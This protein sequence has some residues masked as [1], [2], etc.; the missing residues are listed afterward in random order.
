[1][2]TAV[3]IG[4]LSSQG[5]QGQHFR[6]SRWVGPPAQTVLDTEI[7]TAQLFRRWQASPPD[8]FSVRWSGTLIVDRPGIYTFTTVSDGV[9][10]L[11]I[12][13]QLVADNP[14]QR[15]EKL[16]VVGRRHRLDSG[17][18]SVVLEYAHDG[19]PYTLEWW[20]ARDGGA[21]KPVPRRALS[22]G[23]RGRVAIFTRWFDTLWWVV[24][25]A[26][27]LLGAASAMQRVML[28]KAV[29]E[30][31]RRPV[32]LVLRVTVLVAVLVS[33]GWLYLSGAGEH[34][35][36]MNISSATGDQNAYLLDAMQVYANRAGQDPSMLIGQR[37][38]M[39]IYA[40]Y[41]SLFYTPRLSGLEFLEV[42]KIWNIRL[43]LLLVALLGLVFAWHL[44]WIVSVN[45]SLIVAFG[46]FVFKAGYTQ[47]ALL[48]Y[49]LF[50]GMFLTSCHL[51]RVQ[52]AATSVAL[53]ALA[54]TLAGLA[55]LTKALVPP[56]V[57]IFLAVYAVREVVQW[58]RSRRD[59]TKGPEAIKRFAWRMVAG[60]AM[61]VC[62]LAVVYPYVANS[63][64]VFGQ[65]LFNQNTTFYIWYDSGAEAR[66]VMLPHTDDEGRVSMPAEQLPSLG[67]YWRTH[68][69]GQMFD[70]VREGIQNMSVGPYSLP[71][72]YPLLALCIVLYSAF[73]LVV[74]ASNW[75]AFLRLIREH[76]ALSL[77]LLL[78]AAVYLSGSAFFVPTSS[79]GGLRFLLVHVA[80]LLFV[81]S[82]FLARA[83]F[84]LTRWTVAGVG[85]T[86]TAF[87]VAILLLIGGDITLFLWSRLETTYAGF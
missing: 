76:G 59:P 70:R 49:S 40:A 42:S 68:T 12:D 57:A 74:I 11:S 46:Y 21:S 47:P 53:G 45:L 75:S 13:G 38:R 28:L 67:E 41:L 52:G 64:R 87:H 20:W 51:F 26:C 23:S 34:S 31:W 44:P 58:R 84:S 78:Y 83:P 30:W 43:S 33:A 62:F 7:S 22:H 66:A 37:M 50:F 73:A 56:F 77:F 6:G 32:W 81:L 60:G 3:Q 39:P 48:F 16:L 29:R 5:L 79:T 80:P 24:S 1:M 55:Y 36:V 65:Y 72:T 54:G 10:R 86:P 4:L 63:Q 25:G 85:I 18:H 35:R 8:V 69:F 71:A 82:Y 27:L 61:G 2:I 9:S 17:L 14:G 15:F 19:G